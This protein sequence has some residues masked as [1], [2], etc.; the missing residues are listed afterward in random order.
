MKR[1]AVFLDRDGVIN[2]EEGHYYVHR[3]ED[4]VLNP[5]IEENIRM[6]NE[7]GYLVIV[8][9]NQGGVARG[10]YNRKDVENFHSALSNVL[11]KKGARIDEFYFCPHHDS[12]EQCLCRKPKP[13]MI[14][15]AI[16]RFEI[17]AK[18]SFF[19]G[20]HVRDIRAAEN[21]GIRGILVESNRN[22]GPVI[23]NMVP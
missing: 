17:D 12:V 10:L 4:L 1:K 14:Q 7:L 3:V 6:L 11:K 8:I 9:S 2:S 23:K 16:A 22:I 19:I 20:D 5:G 15:K 13:L 18:G 21:A